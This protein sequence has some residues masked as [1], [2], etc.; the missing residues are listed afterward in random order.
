MAG[1]QADIETCAAL[2]CVAPTVVTACT[3]QSTGTVARVRP[4]TGAEVRAQI[5]LVAGEFPIAAC[6]IGLVPTAAVARGLGAAL[7]GELAGRPLVYDPVFRA[8]SGG[9]LALQDLG[10]LVTRLLLP[11][12]TVLTPNLG[13]ACDLT[14]ARDADTAAAALLAAGCAAVL[15]T[16]AVPAA[17]TLTNRLYVPGAASAESFAMVRFA[18]SYHGTGCTL[19]SGIA[20][21]LASGLP[22]RAAVVAAQDFVH[23]A[24][25]GA[26]HLGAHQFIPDR[27]AQWRT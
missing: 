25:A 13:E 16:D 4:S 12:V 7:G 17:D 2:G 23:R 6:K 27:F 3:T 26:H 8:G 18:G 10:A 15:V 1:I 5:R 20:C 9:R 19:A 22:L 14:G 24:V 11:H 21:G